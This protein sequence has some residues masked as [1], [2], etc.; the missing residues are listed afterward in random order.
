MAQIITSELLTNGL[1]MEFWDTYE[2]IKNRLPDEQLGM[3][4]DLS[5]TATNR[6]HDFGYIEAA[7]H[8]EQWV[9][10]AGIPE[11]AMDSTK[12]SVTAY[13]WG[14]R[15]KWMEDD[16]EDEQTQ[17]LLPMARMA[18][19]SFALLPQRFFFDLI[20]ND[21]A[22]NSTLPAVPNAPDGAAMFYAT[23]GDGD[24]RFG[25]SG[26]NLI[27]GGGVT[28]TALIQS[29]YYTALQRFSEFQ[30][31]K[32]YPMFNPGTIDG[33]VVIIY[34]PELREIMEKAFLQK[35][36]GV[37]ITGSNAG[38]TPTNIIFDASRNVTLWCS[39]YLSDA[40]DWFV[41]L[42]NAP[43]KPTFTMER[44]ALRELTSLMDDNNSDS[45]RT[46][47]EEYIQWDSRLGAGI[48]LPYA[49]IKVTNT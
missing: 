18:G 17:S 8:A 45:V 6:K 10:G 20:T 3:V 24:D 28:T 9:R 7:P 32:G 25:V 49:A 44:R 12:F 13:N 39:S 35:R 46:T 4:M 21:S 37:D 29:D 30:D 2:K 5:I 1:R 16:R 31:G 40:N 26:G 23:D 15:V 41:F 19:E 22:L 14:R 42:K 43:V 27:S 38:T 47:K 48:A 34:P 33:G 36:Q 11:D